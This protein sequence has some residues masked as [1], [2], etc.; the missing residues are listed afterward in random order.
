[1]LTKDLII[2]SAHVNFGKP[3]FLL[4]RV[5]LLPSL[6]SKMHCVMTCWVLGETIAIV[7]VYLSCTLRIQQIVDPTISSWCHYPW[8][9]HRMSKFSCKLCRTATMQELNKRHILFLY[10]N[11]QI[12]LHFPKRIFV[13][14]S[15]LPLKLNLCNIHRSNI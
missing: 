14:C 12:P 13:I 5:L 15:L 9:S 2:N 4:F 10:R 8:L 3:P 1:M 6:L 11:S 7:S